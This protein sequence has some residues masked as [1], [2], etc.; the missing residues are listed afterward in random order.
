[1]IEKYDII[2][3]GAGIAG[4]GA[5]FNLKKEMPNLKILL[6]DKKEIGANSGY[7]FRNTTQD[8]IKEYKIPVT[9][10]YKG[11]K[12]GTDG[13]TLFKLN[14][15]FYLFNYKDCC[16]SLVKRSE[17]KF[18]IETAI[19]LGKNTIRTN[20]TIYKFKYLIDC[21]GNK[22]FTKN[23]LKKRKPF[24]YWV[25]ITRVLKNKLPNQNYFYY[26]FSNTGYMNDL[27]PMKNKTL[28]GDWQYCKKMDFTRVIPP[29]QNL[30]QKMIPNPIIERISKVASPCT[31]SFP[32]VYK[33][34]FLLGESFG[35][36]TTSSA[37][38]IA[39]TLRTSK[40]LVNAIKNNNPKEYETNW[41]KT[42]LNNYLKF[43]TLRYYGY[44][45][46][47]FEKKIKGTPEIKLICKKF[48]KYPEIFEK[49][50]LCDPD[51]SLP[52]E[53]KKIYPLRKALFQIGCYSY[54]KLRLLEHHL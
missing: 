20:K 40:I 53:I 37:E 51:I 13:Q 31:P 50:L 35:N 28:Q 30:F 4:C 27:Y 10:I 21:S 16:K 23:E 25:G 43:L 36:P 39:P 24:R 45:N 33:N 14:K 47:K 34:I 44:A 6:I 1:M 41:K 26:Q 12:G 18:K 38:G 8:I 46:S 52:D 29:K 17:I 19:T 15:K 22:F 48:S 5:A 9:Q 3:V 7:G 49:I 54:L 11:I 32:L 2:I 42:Y